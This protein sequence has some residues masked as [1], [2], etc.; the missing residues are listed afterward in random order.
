MTVRTPTVLSITDVS[1]PVPAAKH[2]NEV[3]LIVLSTTVITRP[4]GLME[5]M[6][7]HGRIEKW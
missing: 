5:A 2:W 7:G 1:C 4:T 6:K 3:P